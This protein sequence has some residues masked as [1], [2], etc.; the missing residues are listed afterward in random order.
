M[1]ERPVPF[2]SDLYLL[3]ENV[4]FRSPYKECYEL[5]DRTVHALTRWGKHSSY[6]TV[7]TST[8]FHKFSGF[9][10]FSEPGSDSAAAM[11]YQHFRREVFCFSFPCFLFFLFKLVEQIIYNIRFERATFGEVCTVRLL[12]RRC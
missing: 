8:T 12:P 3:E 5:P 4:R 2:S 9:M 6:R 10:A 1:N 7:C 11:L